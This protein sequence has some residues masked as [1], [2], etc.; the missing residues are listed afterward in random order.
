M[1]ADWYETIAK[2]NL[3]KEEYRVLMMLIT[4][5]EFENSHQINQ[6]GLAREL[7]M[8]RQNVHRA[9]K[10]LMKNGILTVIRKKNRTTKYLLKGAFFEYDDFE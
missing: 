7:E 2:M 6:A 8:E 3:T 5:L 10:K 9:L 1:S 4:I